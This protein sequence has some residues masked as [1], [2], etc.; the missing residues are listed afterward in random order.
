MMSNLSIQATEFEPI[1]VAE[2]AP[3]IRQQQAPQTR[4]PAVRGLKVK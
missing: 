1:K 3:V 4:A 2:Q